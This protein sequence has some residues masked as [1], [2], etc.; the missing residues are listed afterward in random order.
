MNDASVGNASCELHW[1]VDGRER[2]CEKHG[3]SDETSQQS[4]AQSTDPGSISDGPDAQ[5]RTLKRTRRLA[6]KWSNRPSSVAY[7]V[8]VAPEGRFADDG[9]IS[10]NDTW[11][12]PTIFLG[13]LLTAIDE[14]SLDLARK[15]L[16]VC[17]Q[18]HLDDCRVHADLRGRATMDLRSSTFTVIDVED[19]CLTGLP[20]LQGDQDTRYIALSYT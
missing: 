1:T 19:M 11:D 20:P 7:I 9:S 17:K 14:S 3:S 8:L 10:D 13:R 2:V 16:E 6:V 4:T 5:V 18:H 12:R 15:W